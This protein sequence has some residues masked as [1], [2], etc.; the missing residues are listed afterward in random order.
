MA[1]DKI[2]S[3]DMAET[4]DKEEIPKEPKTTSSKSKKSK[5]TKEQKKIEELYAKT[6]ELEAQVNQLKD[7]NLRKI[8]EFENYKRRT[9]KE[10]LAHLEFA[11]E[12]LIVEILPALD[13]FE[14][15]LEHAED[16][17]E[18]KTFKEG[19]ELVY[20]KLFSALEKKGLKVMEVIG[21]EFN[22]EKHDALMQVESKKVESGFVVDQHL[23]GYLINEKVIRHAQVLVAK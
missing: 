20:K 17:E 22:S 8:A 21:E 19:V 23:K 15:F 12:G 2:K 16:T 5:K 3:E 14:R 9:E 1:E 10:F 13:D 18:T 4:K 7:Q 11:N 6:G